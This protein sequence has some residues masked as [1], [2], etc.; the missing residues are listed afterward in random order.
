MDGSS[1]GGEGGGDCL[2]E[3]ICISK[4]L[5]RT[6]KSLV[7]YYVQHCKHRIILFVDHNPEPVFLKAK[8]SKNKE[9][10]C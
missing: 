10:L 9:S 8:C 7:Y 1:T 3:E 2:G 4:S 5:T 6:N